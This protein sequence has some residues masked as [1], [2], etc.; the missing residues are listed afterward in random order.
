M[1]VPRVGGHLPDRRSAAPAHD[2]WSRQVLGVMAGGTGR[3]ATRP[4]SSIVA[5]FLV[6]HNQYI[7]NGPRSA[8]P[9]PVTRCV[10]GQGEGRA[11]RLPPPR[12]DTR[13]GGDRSGSMDQS[14]FPE[15]ETRI[16]TAVSLRWIRVSKPS[17]TRPST[18]I[19][20]VMNGA[21]SIFPDS[22]SSMVAGCEFT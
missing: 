20:P 8:P 6:V 15:G 22:T 7:G 4:R 12:K 13:D 10:P 18:P 2:T 5:C 14:P 1:V 11:R 3:R 21:R 19:L 17:S 16:L 9:L